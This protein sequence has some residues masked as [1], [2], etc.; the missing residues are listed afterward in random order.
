[1]STPYAQPI[2]GATVW[3]G[4]GQSWP[5]QGGGHQPGPQQAGFHGPPQPYPPPA[6][7]YPGPQQYGTPPPMPAR[8]PVPGR[9]LPPQD[10]PAFPAEGGW[11]VDEETVRHT[12]RPG[13]PPAR[14]STGRRTVVLSA[15]S[16]IVVATGLLVGGFF[17]LGRVSDA[18]AAAVVGDCLARSGD[19]AVVVPCSDPTAELIVL[20]RL[21][22]RTQVEAGL[23]A[24]TGFPGTTD[25]YWQGREGQRGLVLCLGPK[26]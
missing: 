5:P 16:A 4:A 18:P 8:P 14:R 21:D 20:G 23:S 22:S 3:M 11:V 12:G 13:R 2:D 9:D 26:T 7:P 1:M 17:V 24:C 6:S 25:V 19:S 10:V 15:I